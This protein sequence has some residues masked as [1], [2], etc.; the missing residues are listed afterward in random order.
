MIHL[1]HTVA[2]TLAL[3]VLTG[4]MILSSSSVVLAEEKPEQK[5][6]TPV[7]RLDDMTTFMTKQ[8]TDNQLLQFRAIEK[9]Y[10]TIRAVEDVQ[11]SI[12]KAVTS[13]G[14]SNP[15]I[16]DEMEKSLRDWKDGIRQTMKSAREK[17]DKM[18]LLQDFTQPSSVRRYLKLFD[19]AVSYRNQEVESVPV[20][21]R[22]QC[23][24]LEAT[25]SGTKDQ[26]IGLLTEELGLDKPIKTGSGDL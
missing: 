9:S 15:D 21:E 3:G 13:C 19:E 11:T 8:M 5:K 1:K 24:K 2:L 4:V 16:K 12:A 17:M 26:L 18:I 7:T 14:K 6:E 22:D 25:M 20:S 23:K 10:R